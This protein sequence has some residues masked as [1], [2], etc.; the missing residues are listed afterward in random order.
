MPDPLS[1]AQSIIDGAREV[2]GWWVDE[3]GR[4]EAKKRAA[5]RAKK[6]E[7]LRALHERRFADFARL[8]SELERM[9]NEA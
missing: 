6:K 3:A 1:L 4:I 5:M 7:C 9:C 8:S 2:F